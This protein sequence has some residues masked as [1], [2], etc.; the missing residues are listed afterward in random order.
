[1]QLQAVLELSRRFLA[2]QLEKGDALTSPSHTANYLKHRLSHRE[3]EVF[4]ALWLDNQHRVLKYQELFFGTINSSEV[5]PRVVVEQ[6]LKN[7]AAAVIVCHNHP[8][9][10]AEPSQADRKITSRLTEALA[11]VDVRLLDHMVI[12]DGK[13]VSF[14]ERGWI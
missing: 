3:R 13:P 5:H 2:E 8:S 4:A 9:G 6:A 7:R 12:G 14:A 1:M 11:L 10:I